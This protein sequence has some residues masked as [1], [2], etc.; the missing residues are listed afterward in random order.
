MRFAPLRDV[1]NGSH[2]NT[3]ELMPADD[4][5]RAAE[6][7]PFDFTAALLDGELA[8]FLSA[9]A[10][11]D[12][13]H[14]LIQRQARAIAEGA[15]TDRERAIAAFEWV[16]DNIEYIMGVWNRAASALL[17]DRKGSCSTKANLFVA[18]CRAMQIPAAFHVMKVN[19]KA[20][21]GKVLGPAAAD[22]CSD[23]SV[24]VY[25]S[26]YLHGRWVKCDLSDDRRLC[27]GIGHLNPQTQLVVFDGEHDALL[28]LKPE[29]IYADT[30]PLA[31]IDEML[32]KPRRV[33]ESLIRLIN[34][35]IMFYRH[36]GRGYQSLEESYCDWVALVQTAHGDDFRRYIQECEERFSR[37]S[38]EAEMIRL[39]QAASAN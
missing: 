14:P 21:F 23:V 5:C 3:E 16:R 33:S 18:L 13:E 7:E 36:Y 4:G 19:G 27:E 10:C 2:P 20:Y 26:V 35:G 32:S 34:A 30:A 28:P 11:C 37:P 22:L 31:S 38:P 8:P 24:D 9:T 25:N 12:S 39:A 17:F 29:H 6:P 15:R 1:A